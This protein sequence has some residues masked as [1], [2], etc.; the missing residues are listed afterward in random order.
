MRKFYRNRYSSF[1]AALT[2]KKKLEQEEHKQVK[3][4][5]EKRKRKIK[6]KVIGDAAAIK[7]KF[8][9]EKQHIPTADELWQ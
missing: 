3:E 1:M 2:E 7:S 6:E 4:H 8:M 5:E 9:E